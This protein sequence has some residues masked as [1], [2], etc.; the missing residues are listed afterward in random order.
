MRAVNP[1][2]IRAI[3]AWSKPL[4]ASDRLWETFPPFADFA[5]GSLATLLR[6]KRHSPIMPTRL[7]QVS[8]VV[9]TFCGT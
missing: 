6:S 7:K 9:R 3:I 4:D 2:F 8:A 5:D 1:A